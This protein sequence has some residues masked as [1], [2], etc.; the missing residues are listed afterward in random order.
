MKGKTRSMN[1]LL[2]NFRSIQCIISTL[3]LCICQTSYMLLHISA[4]MS[5]GRQ[6]F[7]PCVMWRSS[8]LYVDEGG[9]GYH[10]SAPYGY[11]D[12]QNATVV[13]TVTGNKPTIA[14]LNAKLAQLKKNLKNHRA[15]TQ[16]ST[17]LKQEADA[18]LESSLS[19]E[20]KD[21]EIMLI[22]MEHA[23]AKKNAMAEHA[24]APEPKTK[25]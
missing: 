16:G 24:A 8:S 14:S 4:S 2:P 15:T 17:G 19:Q 22:Q 25:I 7:S 13:G 20:I 23:D 5:C 11:Q 9:S 18:R 1:K 12:A 21:T 3:L 10:T 6:N